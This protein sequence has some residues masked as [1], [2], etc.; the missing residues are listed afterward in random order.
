MTSKSVYNE[1]KV[2]VTAVFDSAVPRSAAGQVP[3]SM[4]FSRQEYWSGQPFPSPGDFD[5]PKTESEPSILQADSLSSEPP[6]SPT[7]PHWRP[8]Q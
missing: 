8:V 5:K 3:L 6:G 7:G 1:V 2:L 4:E